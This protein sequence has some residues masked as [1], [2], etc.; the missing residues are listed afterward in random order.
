MRGPA[1]FPIMIAAGGTGGH[2]MPAIALGE[3]LKRQHPET[4]LLFVGT[5]VA[6][7]KEILSKTGFDFRLLEVRG[8]RGHNFLSRIRGI[9]DFLGSVRE[10]IERKYTAPAAA[11]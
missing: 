10:A 11:R 4:A 8:I 2:L 7:D 1:V 6:M 5:A 9:F 3:E